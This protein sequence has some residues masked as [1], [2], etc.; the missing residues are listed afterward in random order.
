MERESRKA[1]RYVLT[2][3]E[4]EHLLRR[5]A[6]QYMNTDMTYEEYKEVEDEY[7]RGYS[8]EPVV[9]LG[10]HEHL[11][12]ATNAYPYESTVSSR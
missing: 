12:V 3:F 5:L 2:P 10:Y 4:Q 9:L 11:Q 8:S 7:M 6:E 1:Q